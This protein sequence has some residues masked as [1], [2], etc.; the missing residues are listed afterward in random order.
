M[1][2]VSEGNIPYMADF[3]DE[4]TAPRKTDFHLAIT[5]RDL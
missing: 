2:V 4:G 5:S 3:A 1:L